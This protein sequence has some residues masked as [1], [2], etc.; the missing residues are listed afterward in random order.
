MR[1]KTEMHC[2]P[3]TER[4]LE[5]QWQLIEPLTSSP[6]LALTVRLLLKMAGFAHLKG[7]NFLKIN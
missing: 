3:E 7:T 4:E 1:L 5:Q 6:K 2:K